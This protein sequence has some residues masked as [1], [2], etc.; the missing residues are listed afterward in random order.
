MTAGTTLPGTV[1]D[2][3]ARAGSL[4]VAPAALLSLTLLGVNGLAYVF[5]LLATRVLAPSAFGELAALLNVLLIG[6]VPAAA[7]QTV[8]ALRLGGA[9]RRGASSLP[10]VH[11][12]TVLVA[13][14]VGTVGLLGTWPITE[15]LHLSSVAPVAFLALVLVPHTLVGGYDGMLQGAGRYGRLAVVTATFGGA[16][17]VGAA[18]GLLLGGTSTSALA[19]MAVGAWLG[20][21][22]TWLG[23]GRPGLA[24]PPR[25]LLVGVAHAAGALFGFVLL[26]NLDLLLARHHLTAEQAGEYAVGSIIFKI[27]FWLPQGV[28]VMLVPK[29]A[30]PEQR[31]RALPSAVLLVAGI[32]G[33]LVLAT[34]VLRGSALSVLGGEEYGA[35]LG[36]TVWL[37]ATTGTALAIAQLLLYSGIAR[38]DRVAMLTAWGAAGLE[39]VTVGVLSATGRVSPVTIAITACAVATSLV[40]LGLVRMRFEAH[41]PEAVDHREPEE[42]LAMDTTSSADLGISPA[43]ARRADAAGDPQACLRPREDAPTSGPGRRS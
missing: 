26:V 41:H 25:G 28:G 38:A 2:V 10:R 22:G 20:A 4:A 11:G 23:T 40:V 39:V 9:A 21:A 36:G 30:D 29:L 24:R 6:V 34:A 3:P 7:L 33:L 8:T 13:A 18:T 14:G 43:E 16:K 17:M 1:P 37:F 5:T 19:G 27:A 32:G 12:V 42:V 15:L 35:E 31:R